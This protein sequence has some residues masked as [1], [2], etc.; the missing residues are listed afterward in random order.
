MSY[1]IYIIQQ[2]RVCKLLCASGVKW[3]RSIAVDSCKTKN[4]FWKNRRKEGKINIL[5]WRFPL[6]PF[7]WDSS[8]LESKCRVDLS[9]HVTNFSSALSCQSITHLQ[10]QPLLSSNSVC[11]Q[12]Q[13]SEGS[14]QAHGDGSSTYSTGPKVKQ[15][16]TCAVHKYL[17]W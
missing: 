10:Q 11:Q 8:K 15:S 16:E 7:W 1:L 5:L 13:E 14:V 12:G 2:Y 4:G 9:F 17:G 3:C 6:N